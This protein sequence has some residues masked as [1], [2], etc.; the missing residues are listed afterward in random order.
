MP[1]SLEKLIVALDAP[2]TDILWRAAVGFCFLPNYLNLIGI[3][4]WVPLLL[5]LLGTLFAMRLGAG[6]ARAVLPFSRAAKDTW[7]ARRALGKE[8]DSYQWR[9]LLGFGAGML[10]FVTIQR[11]ATPKAWILAAVL[12]AAGCLGSLFWWRVRGGTATATGKA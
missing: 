12:V 5:C 9:K 7:A 2:L 3:D 11:Q 6:V 4:S 1:V 10:G 8:F